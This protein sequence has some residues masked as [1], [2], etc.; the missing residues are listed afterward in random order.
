MTFYVLAAVFEGLALEGAN[1]LPSRHTGLGGG[2][3]EKATAGIKSGSVAAGK[4][5][6]EK[7]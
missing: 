2:N 6:T 5:I 4:G 7:K 3:V 1:A